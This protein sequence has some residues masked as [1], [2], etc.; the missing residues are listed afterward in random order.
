[1]KAEVVADTLELALKPSGCNQA[2]VAHKPRLL[3]DN[4]SCYISTWL[5]GSMIGI[6][7]MSVA[8]PTIL[9]QVGLIF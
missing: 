9:R 3:S 8:L 7:S 2:K 5:N 6:K 1:M 4:G